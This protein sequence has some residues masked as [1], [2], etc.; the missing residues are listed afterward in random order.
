MLDWL[1]QHWAATLAAIAAPVSI[2]AALGVIFF[3]VPAL[4]EGRDA[5]ARLVRIA[6][7]SCLNYRDQLARRVL[8][9]DQFRFVVAGLATDCPPEPLRP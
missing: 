8:T 7:I 2:L 5:Q 3:A 1:Q 9:R 6:P 4:N